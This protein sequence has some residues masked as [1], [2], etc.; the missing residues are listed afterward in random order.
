MRTRV[1]AMPDLQKDLCAGHIGEAHR[2]L[3]E[4]ADPK[5]NDIRFVANASRGDGT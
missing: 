3:S 5:A 4:N 1:G 2:D